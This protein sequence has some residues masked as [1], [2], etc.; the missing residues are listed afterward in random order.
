MT[1]CSIKINLQC[2]SIFLPLGFYNTSLTFVDYVNID[3]LKIYFNVLRMTT[4]VFD[5]EY[6]RM[7]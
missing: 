2:S 4:I 5:I 6:T 7:I 3:P 1:Q